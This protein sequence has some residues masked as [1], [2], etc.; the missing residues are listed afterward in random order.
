[1]AAEIAVI[2]A[3]ICSTV[4]LFGKSGVPY[5]APFRNGRRLTACPVSLSVTGP[6]V[7]SI[8]Q[9]LLMHQ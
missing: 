3:W 1:M 4:K 7:G 2:L 8:A 9:Y 5:I 6:V